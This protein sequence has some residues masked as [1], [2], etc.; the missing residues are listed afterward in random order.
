[1]T[2]IEPQGFFFHCMAGREG[3]IDT[4]VKTSRSGYLQRCLIKHLE[5]L[6]VTYDGTVRD[7]DR[8]VVQF[9]Y[10]EDGM[11]ILKSQFL[12]EK[13]IPFLV[14][15]LNAIKNDEKIEELRSS[16]EIDDKLKKHLKKIKNYKKKHGSTLQRPA[17]DHNVRKC[18]PTVASQFPPHYTFGAL[19]ECAEDILE[20]YF[21]NNVGADKDN[22]RDMF[23]QKTIESLAEPG[24]PVGLLAAQSIGKD[25]ILF[26]SL[27]FLL[28]VFYY[29]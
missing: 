23:S 22:I 9:M 18:P 2:G 26:Y 3:L 21:K 7:S 12:K 24:E 11:D 4:A 16:P 14:E 28:K 15:N 13:Q 8:S 5:G 25:K 1:M 17:R 19:S 6:T 29:R 27:L 10:G 20:K